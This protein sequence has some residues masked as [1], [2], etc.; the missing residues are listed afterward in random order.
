MAGGA[1]KPG[2]KVDRDESGLTARERQ[3]LEL[4]NRG[5][6]RKDIETDLGLTKARIGALCKSI[7][8]KGIELPPPNTGN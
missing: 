5:R 1:T 7:T 2:Y 6:T 8:N 3:V 4:L